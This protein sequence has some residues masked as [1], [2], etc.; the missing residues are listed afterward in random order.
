MENNGH[1]RL[2]RMFSGAPLLSMRETIQPG[3]QTPNCAKQ[4][5]FV[6]SVSGGMHHSAAINQRDTV[7]VLSELALEMRG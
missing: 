2:L 3:M 5:L 6:H 7:L 4:T 1:S